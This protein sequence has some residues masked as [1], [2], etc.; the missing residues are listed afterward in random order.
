[1][2]TGLFFARGSECGDGGCVGEAR[3][4]IANVS[5][6]ISSDRPSERLMI[7]MRRPRY[8]IDGAEYHVIA[9][10]NRGEF[11]LR[12]DSVK[13][14]LMK[15]FEEAHQKYRFSVWDFTVMDNHFHF[16]MRPKKGESLSRI[17]QWILSVFAIRFNRRFGLIGHVWY[18][19]FKSKLI[20]SL[21]QWLATFLYIAHNPVRAGLVADPMEYRYS[22]VNRI[23][24]SDFSVV[25]K[26]T[27]LAMLLVPEYVLRRDLL[28]APATR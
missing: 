27:I 9:R 8:L 4:H 28:P 10:I 13:D 19:R 20:V 25:S 7:G 17:M 12:D 1:M 26:P 21:Q 16:I 2:S 15:V 14:L 23:R 3:V 11:V 18:D 24:N 22:G 6:D 5:T